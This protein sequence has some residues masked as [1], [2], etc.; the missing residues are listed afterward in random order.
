MSALTKAK[1][2]LRDALGLHESSDAD[3]IAVAAAT[4]VSQ[5][6]EILHL[7]QQV[8]QL[9]KLTDDLHASKQGAIVEQGKTRD[10]AL[11]AERRVRALRTALHVLTDPEDA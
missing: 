10:R 6:M 7:K 4:I 1:A 8:A 11:V 9:D 3:L 2:T 5:S